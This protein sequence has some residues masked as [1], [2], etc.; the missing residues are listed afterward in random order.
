MI[1]NASSG[2]MI[3]TLTNDDISTILLTLKL[4][5]IVTI[6]LMIIGTPMA[7]WLS[8]TKSIF[9]APIAAIVALPLILP[10]TVIGFYLLILMSPNGFIG[11][12]TLFLG[13]GTLPFTFWGLV[14]ASL[15]YSLPFVVQPIQNA[16]EMIGDRPLEIAATL[17]ASPMDRFFTIIVPMAKSGFFTGAVLGFAHTVGEFGIVLMIGG[18]IP[19]ETRVVSV[20]IYDYVEALNYENAHILSAI[21]LIFAF[22]CLFLLH[23]FSG[24]KWKLG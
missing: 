16:F 15:I 2:G 18:S 3:M 12:M 7:W 22:T 14:V 23:I 6:L 4:A 9:K 10:P 20:Q 21:L 17:N 8:R 11:Q 24:K 19:N 5:S 13:I 1:S